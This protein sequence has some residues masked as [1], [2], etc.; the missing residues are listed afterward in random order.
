MK[1]LSVGTGEGESQDDKRASRIIYTES[2][3][4]PSNDGLAMSFRDFETGRRYDISLSQTINGE[5][6]EVSSTFYITAKITEPDGKENEFTVGH[7]SF[8]RE[9]VQ[10]YRISRI[11]TNSTNSALVFVVE[12]EMYSADGISVRYMVETVDL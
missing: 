11:L 8:E 1:R 10:G 6:E 5:G 3:Y 7:P 12:K 2:R 9:G 4:A